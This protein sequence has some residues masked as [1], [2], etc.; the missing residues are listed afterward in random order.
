MGVEMI[1]VLFK[2]TEYNRQGEQRIH[3]HAIYGV[4]TKWARYL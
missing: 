2:C 1:D 3:G 4:P